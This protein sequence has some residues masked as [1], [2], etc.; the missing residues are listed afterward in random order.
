MH[1][2]P[3][4]NS[5][6]SAEC[7]ASSAASA[8]AR[9]RACI[10]RPLFPHPPFFP[11]QP[12]KHWHAPHADTLPVLSRSLAHSLSLSLSLSL[13][14][15]VPISVSLC[16]SLSLSFTHSLSLS[17]SHRTPSRTLHR[18][19]ESGPPRLPPPP[20]RPP[21]AGSRTWRR[22]RSRSSSGAGCEPAGRP[23]GR[24]DG[25][26]LAGRAYKPKEDESRVAAAAGGRGGGSRARP[27]GRAAAAA[28]TPASPPP[29]GGRRGSLTRLALCPPLRQG[30]F[31]EPPGRAR[32]GPRRDRAVGCNESDS[33]RLL[34]RIECNGFARIRPSSSKGGFG[35]PRRNDDSEPVG[36]RTCRPRG[37]TTLRWRG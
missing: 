13:S 23:D 35:P 30:P 17:H 9:R 1:R 31:L 18:P 26:P 24:T 34:T 16:L 37:R 21:P 2:G 8:P 29:G 7:P 12:S 5:A 10:K 25:Q 14:V 6:S 11:Y 20:R 19:A 15:S 22:R 32:G 27:G 28:I 33:D 3:C 36:W 4:R